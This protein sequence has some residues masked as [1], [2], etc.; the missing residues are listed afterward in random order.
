LRWKYATPYLCNF[1]VPLLLAAFSIWIFMSAQFS[2]TLSIL[3]HFYWHVFTVWTVVRSF[4]SVLFQSLS[5]EKSLDSCPR[6]FHRQCKNPSPL[7]SVQGFVADALCIP[8]CLLPL[9]KQGCM[10]FSSCTILSY[11]Y[12]VWKNKSLRPP[13]PKLVSVKL[14]K[15]DFIKHTFMFMFQL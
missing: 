15:L 10:P 5:T 2:Q 4:F 11:R 6:V 1:F 7:L 9:I 14:W 13:F 8:P 12:S 3:Y